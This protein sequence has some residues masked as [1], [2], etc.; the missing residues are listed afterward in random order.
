MPLETDEIDVIRGT[1][2]VYSNISSSYP[3]GLWDEKKIIFENKGG[4]QLAQTVFTF[5]IL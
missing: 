5:I 2:L 1:K 4:K 3:T